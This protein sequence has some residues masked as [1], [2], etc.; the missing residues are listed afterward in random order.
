MGESHGI[1]KTAMGIH[2]TCPNGHRLHVKSF[3]AGKRGICPHCDSRFDIPAADTGRVE[4]VVPAAGESAEDQMCQPVLAVAGQTSTLAGRRAS[5]VVAGASSSAV[6]TSRVPLAQGIE[7]ADWYVRPGSGGQ[8]GPSDE[9][10]LRQWIREN[11]VDADSLVWREDWPEWRR[12]GD[13]FAELAP[14]HPAA[15]PAFVDIPDLSQIS[16]K[17]PA[18]G[19]TT[20]DRAYTSG[21]P[22]HSAKR[23][24]YLARSS[25]SGKDASK[26]MVVLLSLMVM[27]LAIALVLIVVYFGQD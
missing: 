13:V 20:L 27:V 16:G 8:Y 15:H 4:A 25:R 3:L 14:P 7:A 21:Q 26:R 12:A 5:D 11:R 2:F 10:L 6:A 24:S 19:V 22:D 18:G 17:G 23:R 1:E 9:S